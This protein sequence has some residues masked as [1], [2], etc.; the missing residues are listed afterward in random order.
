MWRVVTDDVELGGVT[1]PRGASVMLRYGSANR[2][3]THYDAADRVRLDRE[4]PRD[5]LAFG[6]G[7]HFCIGAALARSEMSIALELLLSRTSWI[8][9]VPGQDLTR[10]PHLL[11]RGLPRLVVT[12]AGVSPAG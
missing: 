10:P 1:I 4:A 3:E 7:I 5:H 8:D 12:L 6:G 11:I 2:D 9:L